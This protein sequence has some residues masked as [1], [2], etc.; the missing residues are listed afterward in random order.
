VVG[1]YEM[2]RRVKKSIAALKEALI[3]LMV[4]KEFREITISEIVQ[5]ADLNRGTFYKH[6]QYKEDLFNDVID[7]VM[8]DLIESYQAPYKTIEVLDIER[9]Q[10]STIRIF[11]HVENH[12]TFYQMILKPTALSGFQNRLGTVIKQLSLEDLLVG[13]DNKAINKDLL[14]SYHA[15]SIL[16]MIIQ[17]VQDEFKNTP[18]Y[19]AEQLVKI[20]H[21]RPI[22]VTVPKK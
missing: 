19:M 4:E 8:N 11:H 20:I 18:E 14:A 5:R 2:D 9:S 22:G 10:S 12:R 17:W 7:D 1:G 6:F 16:G 21:Y 13:S 15:Y 3:S